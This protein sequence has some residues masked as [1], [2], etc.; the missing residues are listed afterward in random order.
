MNLIDP[1]NKRNISTFSFDASNHVSK[2][3]GNDSQNFL[4]ETNTERVLPA[5]LSSETYKIFK[6]CTTEL[7]FSQSLQNFMLQHGLKIHNVPSDGLCFLHCIR[8]YFKQFIKKDLSVIDIRGLYE[9]MLRES[10]EL[11][12]TVIFDDPIASNNTS[13]NDSVAAGID[14]YF[15][16]HNYNNNF[17]D[18]I[19]NLASKIF[20][21]A[22]TIIEAHCN[23]S[24]DYTL[25]NIIHQNETIDKKLEQ[26]LIMLLRKI[27]LDGNYNECTHY[28]LLIP[29][30]IQILFKF[31]SSG[32]KTI[33]SDN[34]S[35]IIEETSILNEPTL[36][37]NNSLNSAE[38]L[39]QN[40]ERKDESLS[41]EKKKRKI[42]KPCLSERGQKQQD[43]L[44]NN[45][46]FIYLMKKRKYSI[47]IK[48]R[49][50]ILYFK[51]K[52]KKDGY[53]Y[54]THD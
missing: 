24:N 53:R 41:E 51:R 13:I 34:S 19:I 29:S 49:L 31:S 42:F 48:L 1:L 11:R 5:I 46:L 18:I 2:K 17:T 44:S 3:N 54:S 28:Q 38:Q 33:I 43:A 52:Y 50:I 32:D 8:L 25:T 30:S 7:Y 10:D 37:Q 23:E 27:D 6:S 22:I 36:S 21:I 26:H 35:I 20:N 14:L 15:N 47:F 4:L 40:M 9:K 45:Y 12:S 39:A 16:Q